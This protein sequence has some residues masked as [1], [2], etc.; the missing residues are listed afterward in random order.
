MRVPSFERFQ[1]F[2]QVTAFFVCGMVVGSAVYSGLEN[3]QYNRAILEN[4]KLK[5]E[6]QSV[7]K[8]LKQAEQIRKQNVIKNIVVHIEEPPG[9][10]KIDVLTEAELKRRLKE[11]L[12]IF[13]GRSIYNID[14]DA[15]LARRL[16]QQKTYDK[17]GDKDYVVNVKT[18]L[19]VDRVM[20]VWAE[21]EVHVP[22]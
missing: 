13:L 5:D 8:D 20:Q 11:D 9:K 1:R 2:M 19:V 14:S 6:L 3:D 18:V 22:D 10:T 15:L 12:S 16:L 7:K 21:T 17:I 4:Y